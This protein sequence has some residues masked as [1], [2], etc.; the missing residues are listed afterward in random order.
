MDGAT[1]MGISRP[2]APAFR[3]AWRGVTNSVG[4]VSGDGRAAFYF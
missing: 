3:R 1:G 2:V 4:G